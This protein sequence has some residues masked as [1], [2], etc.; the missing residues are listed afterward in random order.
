[1]YRCQHLSF[2]YVFITLKGKTSTHFLKW[3]LHVCLHLL[4]KY[5]K[6][7]V[8][9]EMLCHTFIWQKYFENTC[10]SSFRLS[11]RKFWFLWLKLLRKFSVSIL[12]PL[13][14]SKKLKVKY[15]A[16]CSNQI[17]PCIFVIIIACT[18]NRSSTRYVIGWT[19]DRCHTFKNHTGLVLHD[20]HNSYSHNSHNSYS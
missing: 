8:V 11:W 15:A 16:Y 3:W 17:D 14:F 5:R 18:S 13:K 6:A 9:N 4:L 1:M 19:V 10:V 7:Y 20:Q 12:K 2:F